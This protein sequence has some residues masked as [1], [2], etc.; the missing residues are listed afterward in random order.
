MSEE[1]KNSNQQKEC[2]TTAYKV[3]IG[4]LVAI[5]LILAWMLWDSKK[6]NQVI[7]DENIEVNAEKL[8]LEQELNSL[9][10]EHNT[11]KAEYGE[12]SEQM[13]EKDSIIQANAEEIKKMLARTHDY[14][15]VKRQLK[16][17]RG[18][19]QSYIDQLDSLYTVNHKLEEE[20]VGYKQ[21]LTKAN[22]KTR[23]QADSIENYR[24]KVEVG[25][26]MKAYNVS[27][28]GINLKGKTMREVETLKA[29][30]V[31]R[32]KICFTI[33][34]NPL[35]KAGK[36]TVYIRLARPDKQ[37]IARGMGDEYAFEVNGQKLQ[38]SMKQEVDYQNRAMN[39]CLNWDKRTDDSAMKGKYHI[40]VYLDGEE[41]GQSSFT[42][43]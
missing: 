24:A 17:L 12:L 43:E 33:A 22:T 21:D 16:I 31:D 4:V 35:V 25:S 14:R 11:I 29:R 27:G 5:I 2:K 9:M 39:L 28:K 42:L 26:R 15:K 23:A 37:I 13:S 7:S 30:N 20:I 18:I 38:Y 41:I 32:V 8:G 36:R 1:I 6:D 10:D 34:E 3:T 19:Q 40:S